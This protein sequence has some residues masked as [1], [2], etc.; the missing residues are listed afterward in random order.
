MRMKLACTKKVHPLPPQAQV[1]IQ[2]CTK[3]DTNVQKHHLH[4]FFLQP[5]NVCSVFFTFFS[6]QEEGGKLYKKIVGN[7]FKF[8]N[9][10]AN[11]LSIQPTDDVVH[12]YIA[13]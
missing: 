12:K 2:V 11:V 1:F 6:L 7:I 10:G 13:L 8:A 9:D 5:S 3:N 4:F